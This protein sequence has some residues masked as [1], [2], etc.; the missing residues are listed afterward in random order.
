MRIRLFAAF[1]LSGLIAFLVVPSQAQ[2]LPTCADLHLVPAPR[3]CK[4]VKSVAIGSSGIR[5]IS[6]RNS[7]DE[8][9]G[10]DL[11]ESLK[12][13]GIANG[14][15]NAGTVRLERLARSAPGASSRSRKRPT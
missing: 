12:D 6:E 15:E 9:A 5:V 11:E 4:T 2:S 8:F 7:E 3:E 14:K 13:L 1:C 10:K